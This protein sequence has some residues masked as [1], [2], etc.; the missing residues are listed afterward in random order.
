[1]LKR[2]AASAY[3]TFVSAGWQ[4]EP[5]FTEKDMIVLFPTLWKV[6]KEQL[7]GSSQEWLSRGAIC[8]TRCFRCGFHRH[9]QQQSWHCYPGL[10]RAGPS[11]GRALS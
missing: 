10:T 1:M 2:F 3:N 7:A 5:E 9:E 11:R 6:R 8:W 4:P